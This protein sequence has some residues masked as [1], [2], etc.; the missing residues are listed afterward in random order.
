MF[1]SPTIVWESGTMRVDTGE[2]NL[3]LF[4]ARIYSISFPKY[5]TYYQFSTKKNPIA[6]RD[7]SFLFCKIW[8]VNNS[9]KNTVMKI[10]L[11]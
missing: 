11:Y 3:H 8:L 6:Y 1:Y 5:S 7:V 4:T 10:K 9:T 2:T